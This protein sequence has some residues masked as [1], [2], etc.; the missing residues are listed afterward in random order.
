LGLTYIASVLKKK[1]H[2][3]RFLSLT[4]PD[5]KAISEQAVEAGIVLISVATDSFRLCQDV[6]KYIKTI[7]KVPVILGG[8]HPT[9]CPDEC[10]SLEGV[11]A[12]CLGEGE[13]A[14]SELLE[15]IAQKRGYTNIEN[16]WVKDSYGSIRKN[17]LRPLI[18][19]LDTLPFPDYGIF[20]GQVNFNILPVIL[21]R[22]C[23]FN[24]TYCC[25]HTLR[26]L[27]E[28]K[29]DLLRRHS[30]EYSIKM[31]DILLSQFN[32]IKE[33]EF[34]DD[35]FTINKIWLKDFLKEFS[36]FEIKFICNSRFDVLDEEVIK[37]LSENGCVRMNVAVESGNEKI[38]KEVLGR[39]MPNKDII[40]KARLI[41]KYKIH[42]HTHN[43]VGI[44]YEKEADILE[45]VKL[46]RHN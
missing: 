11:S 25:N 34:Y 40:E 2:S 16:L 44:P 29:G 1:G 38:R 7:T 39:F 6:V 3:V 24:C 10:I 17:S 30:I 20:E 27:Y 4:E 22:G 28:G 35:T 45:T 15:A 43:M 36:K 19:D 21:S 8:M 33:I 37:L 18:S 9:V 12:I 42:L 46:N 32:D 14:I 23:P 5:K 41:K 31:I 26:K 13:D